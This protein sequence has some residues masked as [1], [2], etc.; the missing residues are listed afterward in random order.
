MTASISAPATQPLSFSVVEIGKRFLKLI[1]GLESRNDLSL[2]RIHEVMG[3]SLPP[4]EPGK[5]STAAGSQELG[6]GWR[7]IIDYV[8][9]SPSLQE[10]VG[11]SFWH[12]SDQFADMSPVCALDFEYYHN[13]LV[14]MG[15]LAEPKYGEIG[16]LRAWLYTKFKKSDGTVDM[17]ISIIPQNVIAREA[18]RLCVKS[19]STLN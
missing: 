3:V 13:A 6:G 8:P 15:F 17:T 18:G 14:A 1:A 2:E 19:I 10:G 11:L 5:L 4:V 9:E 7:Y 16:E 12:Q